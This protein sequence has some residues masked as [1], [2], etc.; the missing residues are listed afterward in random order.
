MGIETSMKTFAKAF[1]SLN[2]GDVEIAD[3]AEWHEVA[4]NTV[5]SILVNHASR[6]I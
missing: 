6:T 2:G 1:P 5:P 3:G 4:R